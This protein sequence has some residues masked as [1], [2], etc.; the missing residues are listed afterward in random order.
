M[1]LWRLHDRLDFISARLKDGAQR[2]SILTVRPAAVGRTRLQ[3]NRGAA[4]VL[5][6]APR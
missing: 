5:F 3:P 4:A 2:R 6:L 1:A